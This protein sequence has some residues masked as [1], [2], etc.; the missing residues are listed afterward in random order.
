MKRLSKNGL[1][2]KCFSEQHYFLTTY[3]KNPFY[4]AL[5]FFCISSLF[6]NIYLLLMQKINKEYENCMKNTTLM[7]KEDC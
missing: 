3:K 5:Q 4:V 1:Q 6:F 7:K 2:H